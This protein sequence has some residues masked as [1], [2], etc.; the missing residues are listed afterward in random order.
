MQ[1]AASY[2]LHGTLQRV[3]PPPRLFPHPSALQ[4]FLLRRRN[5]LLSDSDGWAAGVQRVDVYA[6]LL[7]VGVVGWR[8]EG[9]WK[10]V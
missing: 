5:L 1:R 8:R 6:W 10:L 3:T 7:Q 9:R 2:R 4:R